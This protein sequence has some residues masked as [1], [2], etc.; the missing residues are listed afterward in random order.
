MKILTNKFQIFHHPTD[1]KL[2]K[3]L[4]DYADYWNHYYH[5]DAIATDEEFDSLEQKLYKYPDCRD[6]IEAEKERIFNYNKSNNNHVAVSLFKIKEADLNKRENTMFK[7]LQKN[8]FL[9]H[10]I[11]YRRLIGANQFLIAPKMDG[12]ALKIELNYQKDIER[13]ITRGGVDYTEKLKNNTSIVNMIKF[14][15][16]RQLNLSL[17][18][19]E[20][21]IRKSTFNKKYGPERDELDYGHLQKLKNPRNAVNSLISSDDFNVYNDL[22]FVPLTDGINPINLGT[23]NNG[24]DSV[25]FKVR[26]LEE[27]MDLKQFYDRFKEIDFLIDGIVLAF[28][29]KERIIKDNYP[30]NMVALKY[31][32][33]SKETEVIDIEWTQKKTGK[34]NP[35]LKLKPLMLDG[36][37][38]TG[39]TIYNHDQLVNK[40]KCGVGAIVAIRKGDEI[41]PKITSTTK[42][43]DDYR[44]PE[45]TF[46]D[47]KNLF[48]NDNDK[49]SKKQKFILGLQTLEIEGIG[50]KLAEQIGETLNYDIIECFNV[51]NKPVL[52]Q[53]LG[54]MSANFKKICKIYE[55]KNLPLNSLIKSLQINGCG[56]VLSMRFA[57]MMTKMEDF[58]QD[59]IDENVFNDVAKTTGVS[60]QLIK[61]SIK[62]LHSFGVKVI[63]PIDVNSDV[64]TYEMTGN[65]NI[66]GITKNKFKELVKQK[67]PNSLHTTLT[68]NTKYLIVDDINSTSSKANKARRY[69]IKLLTYKQALENGFE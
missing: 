26:T 34:L 39:V 19:G 37:E 24:F 30:L 13:I 43:S 29:V 50:P 68:K 54:P 42:E 2:T 32:S 16:E 67:Y 65:P 15:K 25:W 27:L 60:N 14:I 20:M 62:R 52:T 10:N 12:G 61:E 69:N 45:N 31:K 46:I 33:E 56:E 1:E 47:G 55:I 48:F 38:I 3:M 23:V 41:T 63:K 6:L 9:R 4:H 36:A 51:N 7:L 5:G 66:A 49:E 21:V 40:Y 53:V 18:T 28:P 35:V 64:I 22:I 17:I 59:G 44:I 58:K 57:R 8:W 11:N